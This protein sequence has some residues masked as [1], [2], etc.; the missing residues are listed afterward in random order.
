M[1]KEEL[2]KLIRENNEKIQNQFIDKILDD[3]QFLC[4]KANRKDYEPTEYERTKFYEIYIIVNNMM[5][6]F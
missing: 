6:W 4:E 2:Q 5:K 1:T 3:V